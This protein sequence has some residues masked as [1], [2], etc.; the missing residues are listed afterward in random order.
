MDP[1]LPSS[2]VVRMLVPGD[3]KETADVGDVDR[4]EN[5]NEYMRAGV[6]HLQEDAPP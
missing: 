6:P 3:F 4:Y 2:I 5:F 1:P